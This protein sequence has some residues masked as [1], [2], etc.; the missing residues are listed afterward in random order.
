[1]KELIS[2]HITDSERMNIFLQQ[3]LDINEQ[4]K[5]SQKKEQIKLIG[6]IGEYF[7]EKVIPFVPKI[8]QFYQKKLKDADPK[9][10]IT[11]ADSIGMLYYHMLKSVA[12]KDECYD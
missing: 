9:L 2:E 11:Y 3:V 10:S 12:Q 5:L 7:G 4:S 1:M 6:L 8:L